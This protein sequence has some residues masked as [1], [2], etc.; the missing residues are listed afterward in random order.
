MA[1]TDWLLILSALLSLLVLYL[2]KQIPKRGGTVRYEP[3]DPKMDFQETT[4]DGTRLP[5]K[6]QIKEKR[7]RQ[8][9]TVLLCVIPTVSI[10]VVVIRRLFHN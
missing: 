8:L 7:T 1:L 3:W 4:K 2:T 9:I 6:R 5:S 10:L